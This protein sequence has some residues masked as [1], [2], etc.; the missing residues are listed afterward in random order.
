MESPNKRQRLNDETQPAQ[1]EH[2]Q[3]AKA[4][5]KTPNKCF[6]LLEMADAHRQTRRLACVATTY[7]N[8]KHCHDFCCGAELNCDCE[9]YQASRVFSNRVKLWESGT[10]FDDAATH[11]EPHTPYT[12]D[13]VFL[14]CDDEDV[15]VGYEY[16]NESNFCGFTA[17]FATAEKMINWHTNNGLKDCSLSD[18]CC[19]CF[20]VKVKVN[21]MFTV[22]KLIR[23][24]KATFFDKANQ[25]TY[26]N[27]SDDED[28]DDEDSDDD[29]ATYYAKR[30]KQA[31]EEEKNKPRYDQ[32]LSCVPLSQ[33]PGYEKLT[34]WNRVTFPKG[35]GTI[36]ML[37]QL[38]TNKGMM[39]LFVSDCDTFHV[40]YTQYYKFIPSYRKL[41]KVGDKWSFIW[42]PLNVFDASKCFTDKV[43]AF[44]KDVLHYVT[45][46][47][48]RLTILPEHIMMRDNCDLVLINAYNH[49]GPLPKDYLKTIG[50]D[51]DKCF[52]PKNMI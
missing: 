33:T 41:G 24:G 8:A 51:I 40:K 18:A 28:S 34:D 21:S 17:A 23:K 16:Q 13:S 43:A 48:L 20:H 7:E 19:Y 32:R 15:C 36:E 2:Q 22:D 45:Q 39:E 37:E 27:D 47:G 10:L 44:K 46:T 9:I 25:K 50:N 6:F 49:K 52:P 35:E 38:A 5:K 26:D 3:P 4:A 30:E 31:E 1:T 42:E 14:I 11:V 29:I 12:N